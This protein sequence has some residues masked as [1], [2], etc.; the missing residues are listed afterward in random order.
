MEKSNILFS[1]NTSRGERRKIAET[2][3]I[4]ELGSSSIYLGNSLIL[5]RNKTKKFGQIKDRL[6]SRLKGWKRKTLSKAGKMVLIKLVLQAIPTYTMTTFKLSSGL[7]SNLDRIIRKFW[8]SNTS[9]KAGFCA[10]KA[11]E[12]ISRPKDKGGLDFRRFE[13]LNMAFLSKFSWKMAKGGI[14]SR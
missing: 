10:L 13:D 12:E 6:Q 5:G 1:K 4:K 14:L 3:D 9:E 2:L 8:W 11:W 7:C